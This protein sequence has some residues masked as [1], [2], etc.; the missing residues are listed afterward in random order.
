MRTLL[1]AGLGT[2]LATVGAADAQRMVQRG[3]DASYPIPVRDGG[4]I[5]DLG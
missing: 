4:A 2:A 1:I 3:P 5:A